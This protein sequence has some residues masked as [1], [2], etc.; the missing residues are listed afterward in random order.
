[1]TSIA[2]SRA[3]AIAFMAEFERVKDDRRG[4]AAV[5][6]SD[7][8][9]TSCRLP[10]PIPGDRLPERYRRAADLVDKVL[11]GTKPAD[12]PVEQPT[13]GP[14]P[15]ESYLAGNRRDDRKL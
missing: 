3:K 6:W 5:H 4:D 12:L 14:N 7:Y 10:P 11:R 8:D 13:I 2:W 1:V 9:K 15:R